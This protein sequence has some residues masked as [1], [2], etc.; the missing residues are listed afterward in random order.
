MK[1]IE[2]KIVVLGSQGIVYRK[3]PVSTSSIKKFE[4]LNEKNLLCFESAVSCTCWDFGMSSARIT[5][6]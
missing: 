4:E 6:L 5:S 3:N 1:A 2:A